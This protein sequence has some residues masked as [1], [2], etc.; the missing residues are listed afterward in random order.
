MQDIKSTKL[1]NV[2]HGITLQIPESRHRHTFESH[3]PPR[4]HNLEYH[5]GLNKLH[6]QEEMTC[7]TCGI[8]IFA[9]TDYIVNE[10]IL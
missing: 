2:G 8:V 1:D 4:I 7:V 3:N 10:L 5:D 9:L 6:S